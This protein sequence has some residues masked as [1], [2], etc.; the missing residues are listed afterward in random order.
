MLMWYPCVCVKETQAL[1]R[2]PMHWCSV[3]VDRSLVLQY[4]FVIYGNPYDRLGWEGC[5]LDSQDRMRREW[6]HEAAEALAHRLEQLEQ[7]PAA[8]EAAEAEAEAEAAVGGAPATAAAA[9]EAG[10]GAPPSRG[11][12][13]RAG[14]GEAA[15][16]GELPCAGEAAL[17][18]AQLLGPGGAA[19]A[20]V[21][22]RSAAASIVAACGWR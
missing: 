12:S 19:A 2:L 20:R 7:A 6:V 15:S 11:P 18:R 1:A 9:G 22:L 10:G 4:G 14:R 21:R 13:R 5:G 8:G 3:C 16:E 17:V